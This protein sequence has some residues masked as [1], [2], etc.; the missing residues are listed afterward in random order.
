[1]VE[2]LCIIQARVSS[3]RL[4]SKVMLDLAGKTLLQRVYESV[5]QSTKLD[6]IVIAT[7]NEE[8]DD[9]IELKAQQLNIPYYRGSLNN[10]LKR[11]Y[12]TAS[13]Y[14]GK[15]I[16]RI[17]AD[18]PLI[19]GKLID[20]IIEQFQNSEFQWMGYLNG[21]YGTAPEI[22][23][24]DALESA[25]KNARNDYDKEHVTP[26]MKDCCK[27]H[28]FE[29]PSEFRYP[30]FSAVIDTLDEYHKMVHYFFYCETNNIAPDII[31]FVKYI[32]DYKIDMRVK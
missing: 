6:K 24:Y 8:L 13:L 31:S 22:F 9:I 25:Y 2:N 10:V 20:L 28:F 23:T 17:C 7:S 26:Y 12:D 32:E 30:E 3:S 15:N 21:L 18:S 4:P 16:I 29:V 27:Y 14:Q 19:N 1:M 11:F 5:N